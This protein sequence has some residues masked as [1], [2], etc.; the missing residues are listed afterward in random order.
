MSYVRQRKRGKP[1]CERSKKR[2]SARKIS[3]YARNDSMVYIALCEIAE[4]GKL[5]VKG[6]RND[7]VQE[8]FLAALEMTVGGWGYFT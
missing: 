7:G 5:S 6:A 8:R 2:R 1:F 3:R 4:N